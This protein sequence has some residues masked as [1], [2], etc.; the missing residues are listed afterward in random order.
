[1]TEKQ[2]RESLKDYLPAAGLPENRREALL[3]Q[4]RADGTPASAPL[5][6]KGENDM[7]RYGKLR[8]S[9]VLAMV[10]LLSLT[11]ALAAG[12]SGFVNFRGEP[13]EQPHMVSATPMPEQQASGAEP[14]GEKLAAMFTAVLND[15]RLNPDDRLTIL[16]WQDDADSASS[17]VSEVCIALRSMDDLAEFWDGVPMPAIPD[18]FAFFTGNAY[19]SCAGDSAFEPAGQETT[20]DGI[21]LTYY[22][23]PDGKAV[24]TSCVIYLKDAQGRY[25]SCMMRLMHDDEDVFFKVGEENGVL[26]AVIPGMDEALLIASPGGNALHMSC[27]LEAPAEVWHTDPYMWENGMTTAT[28]DKVR[29]DV[30]SPDLSAE[31]LL[32]MFGG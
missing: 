26:T 32:S 2:L 11:I 31:E 6:Q 20:P 8:V 16:N 23:I 3:A 27:T 13:V 14:E 21:A 22:S 7:T 28:Y 10:L 25:V 19:L 18:G 12:M 4:I 5:H 30:Q 24:A 17:S 15:M 29:I 9:L 1:M